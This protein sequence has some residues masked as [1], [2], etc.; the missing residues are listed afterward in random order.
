[1][2]DR[3]SLQKEEKKNGTETDHGPPSPRTRHAYPCSRSTRTR[4]RP[5]AVTRNHHRPRLSR[6]TIVARPARLVV[7][8]PYRAAAHALRAGAPNGDQIVLNPIKYFYLD[9]C[10]LRHAR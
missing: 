4:H 2:R 6:D 10:R 5:A 9:K 3:W 1:M 7:A 8:A